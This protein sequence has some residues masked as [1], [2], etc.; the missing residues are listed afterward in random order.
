[1]QAAD[2]T[3]AAALRD[4]SARSPQARLRALRNLAPALLEEAKLTAPAWAAANH[5]PRGPEVSAALHAALTAGDPAIAGLAAIGLGLLG[6]A[7]LVQTTI[8]WLDSTDLG[9]DASFLRESAIIALSYLGSAAPAE[10][11]VRPVI[12]RALLRAIASPQ[13]EQ[14]F[15]SAVALAEVEGR[16]AEPALLEALGRER[17]PQ[18]REHLVV[19]LSMLE[20]LGQR[21][22]AA[23]AQ[24]AEDAAEAW[25]LRYEAALTLAAAERTDGVPVLLEALR[26]RLHRDRALEALGRLGPSVGP[27]ALDRIRELARRTLLPGVTRVRAA[28]AWAQCGAGEDGAAGKA[29]L[30]RLAWHPRASVREAV[31]DALAI[32]EPHRDA[33]VR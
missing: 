2:L 1:M 18:V 9:E 31:R 8:G 32:L 14:R 5:H 19:A 17:E 27:Q 30:R 25:T 20:G 12:R 28:Y 3:L 23:L 16:G 24:V 22:I 11:A 7:A 4:C 13:P 29:W 33:P 26:S 10:D 6:D 21:A 15:Q